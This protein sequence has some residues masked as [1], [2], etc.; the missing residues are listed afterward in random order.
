MVV[1]TIIIHNNINWSFL[2][3]KTIN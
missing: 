1:K 2:Y 3:F